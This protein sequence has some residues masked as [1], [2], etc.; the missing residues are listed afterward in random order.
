MTKYRSEILK[1]AET[2]ALTNKEISKVVGCSEKTVLKY[3]GSY[4]FRTKAKTDFD[5]SA[6]EIQKT[7]LAPDIHHP[8]YDE[9]TMEAFNEFI[10][11]YDPDEIVYMGDQMSLDSVSWWLKKKP[12]LKE[13]KRLLKEIDDFD[14]DILKVH[15]NL[16]RENTRRVF[17]IGNHEYRVNTYVQE[18]PELEDL[19]DPI[20]HLNL[21]ERGYVVV[22]LNGI[23][24]IGKLNVIHGYYYNTYHA[25]KTVD[26]FEGNVVYAH[27]HNPQMYTK[28]S[29]IDRKGYHMATALGCLCNIRPEY[30]RNIP[31]FWVNQFAIVEHL[32]A[33]GYYNLYPITIIE[34]SFMY[35]SHY[36]GKKL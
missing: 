15:E 20:R 22:P 9:R 2:T 34:N 32:P 21:L 5:E 14:N 3:A 27:V 4:T 7:I 29:P 17:M 12:L 24:K 16:T 25:K 35:N 19:I 30:K 1:L 10:F 6:W 33:T 23:H 11:D 13:G 26:V 31:N 36:Y 18:N 28:I 8:H